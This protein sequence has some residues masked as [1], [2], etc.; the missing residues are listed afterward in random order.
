MQHVEFFHTE[1]FN[2]NYKRQIASKSISYF[3]DFFWETSFD[4]LWDQ[5]PEGFSDALFPNTGYTYLINLGTPYVMQVGDRKFD[6]KTDGF[7]PRHKAIECYHQ[8]GNRLF[9]VKFKISPVIFEKRVNFSEYRD[10]IFPL[11]YLIDASL[12]TSIKQ[13]DSF[14]ERTQ[15]LTEYFERI[16]DQYAGSLKPIH[17]VSEIMATCE[18]NNDFTTPVEDLAARYNISSRTLQ[19]YFETATSISTKNAL[20]IMRIRRA[21]EHLVK[22]PTTFSSASYGYYD[23]SHFYKHLKSFVQ[24]ETLTKLKP[25]LKLL[26]KLHVRAI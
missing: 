3:V 18:E 26:E 9:G 14:E 4:H 1:H 6:M 22:E 21:T 13:S 19:R 24:K 7:L 11:S 16:I 23:H 25:H 10:Y 12:L 20:Q 2:Q 8:R 17:I 5:Y 15:L